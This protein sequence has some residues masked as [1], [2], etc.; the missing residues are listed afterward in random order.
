MKPKSIAS[1]ITL[2]APSYLM[3]RPPPRVVKAT[4]AEVA[5]M[6]AAQA[7]IVGQID[8]VRAAVADSLGPTAGSDEELEGFV[9]DAD[10][11]QDAR[12]SYI[13]PSGYTT[14][15]LV[16]SARD[17]KL[18]KPEAAVELRLAR[19]PFALVRCKV[20]AVHR[21]GLVYDVLV[22]QGPDMGLLVRVELGL[23]FP[24][25]VLVRAL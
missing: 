23:T 21:S 17:A 18:A 15:R 7:K 6:H 10:M 22:E 14:R 20:L 4:P 5:A 2:P 8:E 12:A 16:R 13:R 24:W 9:V 3:E 25:D 1:R 11:L 19:R